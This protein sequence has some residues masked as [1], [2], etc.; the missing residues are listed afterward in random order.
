MP[1]ATANDVREVIDT[2]L[3]DPDL[4]DILDRVERAWQR[5]YETSD[6]DGTNHI[7]DFEATLAALRIAEGRDRRAESAQ[8]GRTETTYETSVVAALRKRVR[9]LD[10]GRVF[11]RSGRVIRDDDRHVTSTSDS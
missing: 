2:H 9:R 1:E 8:T 3:D 10:P 7:E 6:F 11:G 4:V 5:E